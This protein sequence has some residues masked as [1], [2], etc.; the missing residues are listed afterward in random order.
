MAIGIHSMLLKSSNKL[1][2]F[3]TPSSFTTMAQDVCNTHG[4]DFLIVLIIMYQVEM[5]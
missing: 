2:Q 1:K 4:K 3:Q 5:Y